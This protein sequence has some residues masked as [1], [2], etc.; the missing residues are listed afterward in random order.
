VNQRTANAAVAIGERMDSLKLGVSDGCLRHG[1]K[2]VVIAEPAEVVEKIAHV[3]GR[4][5]YERR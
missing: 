5:W 3:F 2:C 4:W 1:G